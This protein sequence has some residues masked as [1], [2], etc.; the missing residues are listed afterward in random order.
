MLH[1]Q[2]RES[3]GIY[4]RGDD[5]W[6]LPSSTPHPVPGG[7][8]WECHRC[9]IL[10]SPVVSSF[11]PSQKKQRGEELPR[12]RGRQGVCYV[13]HICPMRWSER[14]GG[15]TAT[16]HPLQQLLHSMMVGFGV[17]LARQNAA[18][19]PLSRPETPRGQAESDGMNPKD[20]IFCHP[21][22]PSKPMPPFRGDGGGHRLSAQM[23]YTRIV[24]VGGTNGTAEVAHHAEK[25]GEWGNLS[26]RGP[27]PLPP[28]RLPWATP[29][30]PPWLALLEEQWV[31]RR[32]PTAA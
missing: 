29:A 15:G 25:G 3:Q 19:S 23:V 28:C 24:P 20:R 11:P 1:K 7:G 26:P 17:I 4:R 32:H 6:S 8:S 9:V 16:P 27:T 12:W 14:G 10:T 31:P 21:H 30:S 2:S 22:R 5:T 18:S 13:A